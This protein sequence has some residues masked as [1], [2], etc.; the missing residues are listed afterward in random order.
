MW[1]SNNNSENFLYI[2]NKDHEV[3]DFNAS[4]KQIY[5]FLEKGQVCHRV[6]MQQ[7]TPCDGCPLTLDPGE[8]LITFNHDLQKWVGA[9]RAWIDYPGE[10]QCGVILCSRITDMRR[11]IRER[12]PAMIGKD[13]YIE[14]N[15]TKNAYR[16]ILPDDPIGEKEFSRESLEELILR[17]AEHLVH[18]EDKADFLEFWDI[19]TMISRIR[20]SDNEI[21]GV[22]RECT[23]SGMWDTVYITI[24]PEKYYGLD[25]VMVMAIYTIIPG[26]ISEQREIVEDTMTAAG[27]INYDLMTGLPLRR[28]FW[29]LLDN[30]PMK[31]EFLSRECCI[32]VSDIE[33]FHVFN[34]WHGREAGDALLSEIGSFLKEA[35]QTHHTISG[36]MGGDNF[37]SVFV[38]DPDTV[39]YLRSGITEI[40]ENFRD[41]RGFHPVFGAYRSSN[42]AEKAVDAYDYCMI[43]IRRNPDHQTSAVCWYDEKMVREQAAEI[44][45]TS[46]IRDA[47]A[48][49][50]ICFYLQPKCDMKSGRVVGAEALARWYSPELGFVSPGVFIP[51]LERDGFITELDRYIWEG[52]CQT[53]A[54]WKAAGLPVL[55][56][57]VNVSRIDIF[58]MDIVDT[59]ASLAAQYGL[60]PAD[61]EI[62]ITETAYVEND[63]VIREV[64]SGL[65]AAGFS[66]LIDDFGSGYSSLNF[67]KDVD[68]DAIKLD[69][70]F[71]ELN[72]ENSRKGSDI[73]TS[74]LEMSEKL[75]LT[76]IAEGVETAEQREML[77]YRDCRL[78]QGY[79]FY[80]P[81]P[82]AEFEALLKDEE[83][84]MPGRHVQDFRPH[85]REAAEE[86]QLPAF[87][88]FDEHLSRFLQNLM[89]VG[90]LVRIVDVRSM[91]EY[92]CDPE[93]HLIMQQ[94][95]CYDIWG[96]KDNCR[97]CISRTAVD[98]RKAAAKYESI[99]SDRYYIVAKPIR[100][101]SVLYALE[102]AL[103]IA[104]E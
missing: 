6:L 44:R 45:L 42:L 96:R 43:A 23:K 77:S 53:M 98:S 18:P 55:P 3:V 19:G 33:H 87:H 1:E 26:R 82:V 95:Y 10:G 85:I 15:L 72:E 56:V 68:F 29:N 50:E 64:Q 20:H 25:D 83:K 41:I 57:S 99:G 86:L 67:L 22:F 92:R 71:L 91:R 78:A 58:S 81:M 16:I 36:Y 103:K 66:V 48:N 24:V 79:Y 70:R 62:E 13:L 2:V 27:R 49:G 28:S 88:D 17:T 65:K 38:Y 37:C 76:A 32:V 30:H 52:V 69:I 59:F 102:T 89:C 84:I 5:P 34:N 8:D 93:G 73:I 21:R 31:E 75:N 54:R 94:G 51:V 104:G 97:T 46:R 35:D 61:L 9:K 90:D 63:A 4:M 47:M 40:V 39:E 11:S 60:D 100:I 12:V 74:M 7:E 14:M 101:G 80:K